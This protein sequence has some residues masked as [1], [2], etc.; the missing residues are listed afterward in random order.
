MDTTAMATGAQAGKLLG[1]LAEFDDPHLLLHACEQVRD[2]KY[3][4]WDAH[5]PFPVHGLNDAMGLRGT[6]LPWL[7][8]GG[9]VAG[10]MLALLMQWWMN[11]V[12]YPFLISGKPYFSLPAFIPVVFELTV[13]LSAITAF[14]GMLL[15]AGLPRFHHPVFLSERFKRASDDHFFISIEARDRHFEPDATRQLLESLEGVLQV[16]P[17]IEEDADAH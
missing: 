12:D 1:Y 10:L 6:L 17:L 5:T 16:E 3:R 4:R 8:L 14:F 9:G 7:V 2:A 15:L 13:L 11:A